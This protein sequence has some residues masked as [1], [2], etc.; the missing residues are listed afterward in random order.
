[1]IDLEIKWFYRL[2]KVMYVFFLTTGFIGVLC[3]GWNSKPYQVIDNK[4]SYLNCP[5]GTRYSFDSLDLYFYS[6][7][8]FS[9]YDGKKAIEK[10]NKKMS[11]R[12]PKFGYDLAFDEKFISWSFKTNGSWIEAI[13]WWLLGSLIVF[14]IINI[15]KQSLIYVVYGKKF[16]C[17][18]MLPLVLLNKFGEK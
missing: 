18:Q 12:H 14:L 4:K 1:M 2:V 3:I 5:D 13:E 7:Q 6:K 11:N 10:C 8:P 17:S 16:T 15:I 9:A